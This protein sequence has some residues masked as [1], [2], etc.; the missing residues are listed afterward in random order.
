MRNRLSAF[1]QDAPEELWEGI[2]T[3][4]KDAGLLDTSRKTN[5][6]VVLPW[7]YSSLGAVAA[8]LAL[9]FILRSLRDD[10][11]LHTIPVVGS[12]EKVAMVEPAVTPAEGMLSVTSIEMP[13]LALA[14]TPQEH[15]ADISSQ[16]TPT[17]EQASSGEDKEVTQDEQPVRVKKEETESR[18]GEQTQSRKTRKQALLPMAQVHGSGKSPR[19][20]ISTSAMGGIGANSSTRSVGA[21]ATSIGAD[22]SGWNDS[23]MLGIATYNQGKKVVKEYHHHLP[24]RVGLNVAYTFNRRLG[25][26]S[27]LTYTRLTSDMTDGTSE[28]YLAV[29][30]RLDY[31][32]IPVNLKIKMLSYS[33][34]S[35]YATAGLLGEL[36]V[37]GRTNKDYVISGKIQKSE[38]FRIAEHP[39]QLSAN[40]AL[41]VQFDVMKRVGIYVEPGL[42]YYFDDRSSLS[43][44]YKEK[45]LNFNLNLGVRYT[46]QR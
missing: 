44:I 8:C 39:F 6:H 4:M 10:S 46:I 22:A 12:S 42:S 19:W 2:H 27:G 36:C 28:N 37:S 29:E 21:V 23:P 43:T 38:S 33:R 26:E 20:S 34:L 16:T 35:L 30:Q 1:E 24:V 13:L 31:L 18:E 9:V 40:G 5:R 25:L 32:G 45:Q 14:E 15:H 3:R 7:L 17:D 11:L 41:G